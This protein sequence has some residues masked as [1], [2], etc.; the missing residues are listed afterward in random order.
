[1][2]VNKT[3]NDL[4]LYQWWFYIRR[5]ASIK[6]AFQKP[7]FIRSLIKKLLKLMKGNFAN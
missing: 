5:E 7:S 3:K 4:T 1:M 2:G 6:K